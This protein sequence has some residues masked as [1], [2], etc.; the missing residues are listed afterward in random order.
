[1][2][3]FHSFSSRIGTAFMTL[4]IAYVVYLFY[5]GFHLTEAFDLL[6]N[7][8]IWAVFILYLVLSSYV[9]EWIARK[10]EDESRRMFVS[11]YM[12]SGM[13]VWFVF[14]IPVLFSSFF[15]YI[16]LTLYSSIFTVIAF[17]LFYFIESFTRK[18]RRRPFFVGFPAI[19]ILMIIL[20]VNPS[21]TEGFEAEYRDGEYVA[22]FEKLNGEE[23]VDIPVEEG[24]HYEVSVNWELDD[25][26]L[27]YGLKIH[28]SAS[29]LG[30]I[31][32]IGEDE[33]WLYQVEAHRTDDLQIIYHGK[34]IGGTITFTW[35]E[36]D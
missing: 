14:Y 20:I 34:D 35:R 11:L 32:H 33:E 3:K 24:H 5:T 7:P 31:E 1:M 12:I 27:P 22:T 23:V 4:L 8:I 16:Y 18:S 6:S 10:L 2:G 21:I 25:D 30:N 28:P 17:I 15:V 26:T 19:I 36:L 13:F 9:N 29:N